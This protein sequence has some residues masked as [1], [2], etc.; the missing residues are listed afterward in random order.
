MS[1]ILTTEG[2][3]RYVPT[4]SALSSVPVTRA[5]N[6]Q[7]MAF[8]VMVNAPNSL[9][10]SLTC[11]LN[12]DVNE[13]NINNGGCDQMCFNFDGSFQCFCNAGFV[14]ASDNLNCDGKST[15]PSQCCA[16]R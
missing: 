3:V 16:L 5:S 11:H 8:L 14:L 1:V 13:C 2:V 4:V 10:Y 7:A 6:L 15:S 9:F 12:T